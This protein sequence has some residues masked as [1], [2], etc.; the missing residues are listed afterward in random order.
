MA[1]IDRVFYNSII[2]EA[3]RVNGSPTCILSKNII[4]KLLKNGNLRNKVYSNTCLIYKERFPDEI[5]LYFYPNEEDGIITWIEK[6]WHDKAIK[7]GYMF[8]ENPPKY[9]DSKNDMDIL[10][11]LAFNRYVD[12]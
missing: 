4:F 6:S 12:I 1:K 11:N 7:F 10:D 3:I 2:D 5:N 8:I 9:D